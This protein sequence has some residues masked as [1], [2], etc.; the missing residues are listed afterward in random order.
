MAL[1][2]ASSFAQ[3]LAGHRQKIAEH[4]P[5]GI[6]QLLL[7]RD[8]SYSFPYVS[9]GF[10]SLFNLE[11]QA[12][13][14]DGSI[15]FDV[16]HEDDKPM[17]A[18]TYLNTD[19]LALL[20]RQS[21]RIYHKNQTVLWLETSATPERLTTGDVLWHGFV[22]DITELQLAKQQL[23]ATL[24]N[25][26]NVAVQWYDRYGV[27]RYWNHASELLYG[28][29][30]EEAVG[31]RFSFL[32][33]AS[34]SALQFPAQ[35]KYIEETGQTIAAFECIKN[36]K[37][38]NKRVVTE[39]IFAIPG[40]DEPIFVCIDV[41]ISARKQAEESLKQ[42]EDQFRRLFELSPIGI[43][44]NDFISGRFL[45][46]NQA[47]Q[48][49][50]G[51][52]RDEI[53]A[54][55][56]WRMTPA[57][58]T[59][60]ELAQLQLLK[61]HAV[62]GPYEKEYI[63]KNGSRFPVLLNG[64]RL[65]AGGRQVMWTLVQDISRHKEAEIGLETARAEAES[66]NR[67]KSE[68]LASMSHELRTPLNAII[69]F[70]QLLELGELGGLNEQQQIAVGH[71]MGSGRHLLT[72]IS[73]ILDL[74]RI[75]SGKM[76]LNLANVALQPLINEVVA[77]S[78]PTA[79]VREITIVQSCPAEL[80]ALADASRVKQILLNLV[81]NAVKYNRTN[82]TVSVTAVLTDTFVR[83]TVTDTGV[84][85]T[86]Q[87]QLSL[88][89]PFQRLGAERST[90][91]GTGIG[92]VVCKRLVEALNGRMGFASRFGIGSRFWVDL[93]VATTSASAPNLSYAPQTDADVV[94]G[95]T[96]KLLLIEDG[97]LN[98][99][100]MQH[101]FSKFPNIKLS[102]ASTAEQGL[103]LISEN[104]PDLVLMDI[105]LPG[106]SGVEALKRLKA[107]PKTAEIPVIAASAVAMPD[108]VSEGLR[109]GF[110]DYL[111]KP[112][113]MAELISVVK[114]YLPIKA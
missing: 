100:I 67:A 93:P 87:Q 35:L 55:S 10:C 89:Q 112:I 107:N 5:G 84:G 33:H 82:G 94:P 73:E 103:K 105:N 98:V 81:S 92:L 41:D 69:G 12:L 42:S 101:I 108:D 9:A 16:I 29:T 111:T 57:E 36:D 104:V 13:A 11:E 76:D 18:K 46:V 17:V 85:L 23:T 31:S 72:L 38:A 61:D 96:G 68:F 99:V 7:R 14:K 109:A 77:L 58:Y 56:Y 1:R 75:E 39:T 43:A 15:L 3:E 66:A 83:I 62:Y 50:T 2:K 37:Q 86:E 27:V 63:R 34:E 71:I 22:Q 78:E 32:F 24:E 110:S 8:G 19:N 102:V 48:E 80:Y 21:F 49:A 65:T 74:V 20:T 114:H 45:E 47:L 95:L 70:G 28:W 59:E 6:Y 64:F 91:E 30:A 60:Q 4:V 51:Y 52:S 113:D 106:M 40:R 25:T 90:V 54:M 97:E 26:P 44:L 79:M 88:F 53:L